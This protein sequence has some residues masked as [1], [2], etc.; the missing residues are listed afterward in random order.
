MACLF[1]Y[2]I[3][4]VFTKQFCLTVNFSDINILCTQLF[5][6]TFLCLVYYFSVFYFSTYLFLLVSTYCSRNVLLLTTYLPSTDTGVSVSQ[7]HLWLPQL[8]KKNHSDLFCL[9]IGVSSPCA[10]VVITDEL[11]SFFYLL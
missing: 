9:L 1:H 2:K 7:I 5:Q 11:R 6:L 4:F 10:F 8:K 3:F